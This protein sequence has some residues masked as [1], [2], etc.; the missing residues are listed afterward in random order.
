MYYLARDE[1]GPVGV[2]RFQLED[3][4]YWPE[5]ARGTS[6]FVHRV[7]VHPRAQGRELAQVLLAHAVQLARAEGRSHLRLD[8]NSGRPRLCAV[9][10]R[11][12]IR[13]H[14]H[15]HFGAAVADRF[16]LALPPIGAA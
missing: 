8:C 13:F 2:F 9:Y 10:E 11:F 1:S 12:G 3:A 6:A 16:E 7:A 5:I 4:V 15:K 14:S